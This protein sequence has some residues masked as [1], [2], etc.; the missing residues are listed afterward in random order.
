VALGRLDARRDD[1]GETTDELVAMHLELF[2][3]E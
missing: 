1:R 3:A 2:K